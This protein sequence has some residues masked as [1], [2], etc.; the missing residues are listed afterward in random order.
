MRGY[1]GIGVEGISKALNAGNL[2][3]SA[4]AFGASFVFSIAADPRVQRSHADTS[5]TAENLPWY[6]HDTVA[7]LNLPSGCRLVGVELLDEAVLLPSFHHPLQ[8]AYVF[9]PERGSLSPALLARCDYLI[10]IPTAF[11]I[12]LSTAGAVVMYDRLLNLGRFAERPLSQRGPAPARP[13]HV[14]GGPRFRRHRP[15]SG[16][17]SD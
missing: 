2:F 14:H 8:A 9:G 10:K 4:H 16:P 12:N 3:R 7:E 13:E 15:G 11:C 5:H 17:K 1:F 6:A